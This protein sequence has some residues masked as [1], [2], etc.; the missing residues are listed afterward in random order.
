MAKTAINIT[1]FEGTVNLLLTIVLIRE[2]GIEGA[3]LG[4]LLAAF[5]TS[6]LLLPK[7]IKRI[8]N[9]KL[10][11]VDII[12][13]HMKLLLLF[14]A[15]IVYLYSNISDNYNLEIKL[16]LFVIYLIIIVIMLIKSP[17]YTKLSINNI[18]S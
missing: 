3:A 16:L 1:L 4:T 5:F 8:T 13:F 10:D 7:V 17:L 14:V 2:Y 9:G 12:K 6:F 11:G 18:F 15:P